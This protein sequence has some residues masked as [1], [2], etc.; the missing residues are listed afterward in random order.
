MTKRRDPTAPDSIVL[1][2][3]DIAIA[4]QGCTL[5]EVQDIRQLL[6]K[7]QTVRLYSEVPSYGMPGK[8]DISCRITIE[9][10]IELDILVPDEFLNMVDFDPEF[11]VKDVPEKEP[12]PTDN[13]V[14]F[15]PGSKTP[16]K[17]KS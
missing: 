8:Y 14:P 2:A 7:D 15:K 13:V 11:M 6:L 1:P 10:C 16:P 12:D 3:T 4:Y 5:D 9:K 17:K